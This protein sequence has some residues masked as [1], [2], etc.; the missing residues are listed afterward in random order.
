MILQLCYLHNRI[1]CTGKTT[2]LKGIS[3]LQVKS[4]LGRVHGV[5]PPF[6]GTD[7][8]F[9]PPVFFKVPEKNI[10]FDTSLR[11]TFFHSVK[12]LAWTLVIFL[13][14]SY[15]S[16]NKQ[17]HFSDITSNTSILLPVSMFVHF[18]WKQNARP[19]FFFGCWR[20]CYE[21]LA[22]L[23]ITDTTWY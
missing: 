13:C 11:Q 20:N 9:R 17:F 18:T 5:D 7:E 1:S 2:S 19:V 22:I 3:T 21:Y 12:F 6:Q 4:L 8:K 16:W 15:I 10:D 23:P 14:L